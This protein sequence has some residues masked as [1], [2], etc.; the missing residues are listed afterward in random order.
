MITNIVIG[1]DA[2]GGDNSPS[3]SVRGAS[4]FASENSRVKF[5]FFGDSNILQPLIE[6]EPSLKGRYDISHTSTFISGNENPIKALRSRQESSMYKALNSLN[7]KL[8]DACISSGNTGALMLLS[9]SKLG[10]LP[11]IKRPAIISLFPNKH[12][13]TVLLDI[14]A[15][16]ECDALSLHQFAV[17][18]VC[19]AKL[20]LK[21]DNPRVGILNI[22][23]EAGKGR[24][25]EK[26]TAGLLSNSKS[27]KSF[28]GNVEP[29]DIAEGNVDVVV[30]DGFTGNITIK[31]AEMV[32]GLCMEYIKD[33][34]NRGIC[35]KIAGL[36]AKRFLKKSFS[37]IDHRKY[38]GAMFI[39]INGI[40]VKSH[41]GADAVAFANA[42]GV[43]YNLICNQINSQIMSEMNI[44]QNPEEEG[45]IG[46]LKK[47]AKMF[48]I[49]KK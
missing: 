29:Y 17:M 43:T 46:M 41:G 40:V 16:A 37:K 14:G 25:L 33:A 48:K 13:G 28:I 42:I 32:A 27:I 21:L 8:I 7:D 35:A 30:T 10:V 44:M 6:K 11:Q 18:G 12:K 34:F 15:N 49:G 36:I 19:F 1:I 2:M 45:I 31:V 47:S 39:G 5:I 20:I 3:A 9:I 38:N 24:D 22:G 23:L 26:E 4:I